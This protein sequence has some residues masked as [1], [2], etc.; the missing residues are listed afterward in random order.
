MILSA[1]EII[2]KLIY[3]M[4]NLLIIYTTIELSDYSNFSINFNAYWENIFFKIETAL[5]VHSAWGRF[6]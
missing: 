2:W 1:C 3:G 4:L 6:S 5:L